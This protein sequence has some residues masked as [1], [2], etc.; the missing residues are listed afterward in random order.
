MRKR[1]L[2]VIVAVVAT[3][4]V[5]LAG[6]AWVF[7]YRGT[8]FPQ[9]PNITSSATSCSGSPETCTI[10]LQN[11]GAIAVTA[12]GCTMSF[13]GTTHPTTSTSV[14]LKAGETGVAFTCTADGGMALPGSVVT[15][16]VSLSNGGA[17]PF[18]SS[19]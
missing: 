8:G 18:S 15:G 17:V 9:G 3:A 7:Y 12:T 6:L 1:Q 4:T 16:F 11:S 5:L 2:V 19:S 13:D 14:S 10:L